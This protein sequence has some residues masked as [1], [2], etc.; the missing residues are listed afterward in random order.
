MHTETIWSTSV[1]EQTSAVLH[2]VVQG[3][4]TCTTTHPGSDRT[5][6][7]HEVRSQ[8][9]HFCM[10]GE[11]GGEEL[12]GRAPER[13]GSS[14]KKEEEEGGDKTCRTALPGSSADTTPWY[15]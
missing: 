14:T 4:V 3:V 5:V 1:A 2:V 11:L 12:F 6:T 13:S 8:C 9:V 7:A 10:F 15:A